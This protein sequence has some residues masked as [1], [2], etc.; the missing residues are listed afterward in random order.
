MMSNIANMQRGIQTLPHQDSIF[1]LKPG[2]DSGGGGVAAPAV[3]HQLRE[4]V[5]LKQELNTRNI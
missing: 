3:R 2:R 4:Q 5:F 1:V